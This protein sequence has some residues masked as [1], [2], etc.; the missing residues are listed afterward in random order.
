MN[1]SCK[2]VEGYEI[3]Q[4]LGCGSQGKVKLGRHIDSGLFVA[5]KVIQKTDLHERKI[6]RL[7]Q[8]IESMKMIIH[9]HVI[10]LL[11]VHKDVLYPKRKGEDQHVVFVVMELA[12]GGELFDFML[13]TGCF[14]ERIARSFF[15]QMLLG[16]MSCHENGIYHRDIKPENLLLSSDF[17]LKIADF[18]MS[19]VR[20]PDNV[21]GQLL[22]QCGTKSYMCPEIL[23]GL[24][25]DGA[26]A[27]VWS[28]GVVLFIMLTGFPPFQIANSKDWWFKA[29]SLGSFNAFWAAHERT[30]TISPT[31]RSLIEAIFVIDPARRIGIE[32]MFQ[33][34]FML[35]ECSEPLDLCTELKRRKEVIALMKQRKRYAHM[36]QQHRN[37]Q[38]LQQEF[39][40][41]DQNVARSVGDVETKNELPI[42]S[43][44]KIFDVQCMKDELISR[45]EVA[46]K[47]FAADDAA[48]FVDSKLK[49]TSKEFAFTVYVEQ[50]ELKKVIK[51][52][53]RIA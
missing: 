4:T 38:S 50:A 36:E 12:S 20:T 28:S 49:Y 10:R 33:H 35:Q 29:I 13:H 15:R 24:P 16:L 23:E 34:P 18:G 46:V 27:D 11:A 51:F 22:T 47:S 48:S 19:Y 45:I 43:T 26:K 7:A 1:K 53:I 17:Q 2:V 41:F 21:E 42:L 52:T 40:P 31:A 3:Y 39:N 9:S 25:Y 37:Q 30:A 32:E 14:E 44:Y 6:Y 5:V 8:E